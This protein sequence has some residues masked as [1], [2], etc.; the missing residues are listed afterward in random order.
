MRREVRRSSICVCVGG[1][2]LVGLGHVMGEERDGMV[3]LGV[4]VVGGWA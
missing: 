4:V 1:G 2:G 3:G